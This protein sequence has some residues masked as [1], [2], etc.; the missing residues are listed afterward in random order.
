ML[1]VKVVDN[2]VILSSDEELKMIAEAVAETIGKEGDAAAVHPHWHWHWHC[3]S[4]PMT[5]FWW[6]SLSFCNG[7][8][9]C[10]DVRTSCAMW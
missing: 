10:G 2:A 7:V 4:R 1:L 3:R 8:G 5:V 9:A 6:P